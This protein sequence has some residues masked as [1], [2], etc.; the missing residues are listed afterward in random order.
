MKGSIILSSQLGHFLNY[1]FMCVND[2]H[3]YVCWSFSSSHKLPE[4]FDLC[5]LSAAVFATVIA[6]FLFPY[7]K[8]ATVETSLCFRLSSF[9]KHRSPNATSALIPHLCLKD[10]SRNYFTSR[11]LR[12]T[13]RKTGDNWHSE[14]LTCFTVC[15]LEKDGPIFITE[16]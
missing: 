6:D 4:L 7:Q 8:S 2:N 3:I 10:G 11:L 12:S 1:F 14:A 15:I 5:S 16:M 9:S 13:L